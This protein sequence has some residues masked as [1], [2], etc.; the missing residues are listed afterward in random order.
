MALGGWGDEDARGDRCEDWDG[1][2]TTTGHTK[3]LG[4][5]SALTWKKTVNWINNILQIIDNNI[6]IYNGIRKRY[7]DTLNVIKNIVREIQ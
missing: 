3:H 4:N 2:A 5:T 1:P 7:K 6:Q